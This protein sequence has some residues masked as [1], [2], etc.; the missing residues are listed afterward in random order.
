LKGHDF[1]APNKPDTEECKKP[2]DKTVKGG[3]EK[4][5]QRTVTVA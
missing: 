3:E 5:P 1:S 2:A 4:R